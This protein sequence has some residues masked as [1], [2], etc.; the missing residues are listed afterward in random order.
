MFLGI[1]IL[2]QYFI[3]YLRILYLYTTE[4]PHLPLIFMFF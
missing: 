1:V 2:I 4:S 3:Y